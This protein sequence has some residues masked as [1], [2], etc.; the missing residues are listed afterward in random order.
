MISSVSQTYNW[1]LQPYKTWKGN[2]YNE[3]SLVNARPETNGSWILS[4]Q[5]S[6]SQDG[7]AFL[8]RPIKHWRK[9]LAANRI[10]GGT[11]NISINDI[12][13]PGLYNMSNNKECCDV[14]NNSSSIISNIQQKNNSTIYEDSE[15]TI[16]YAD[17]S[18]CWN[19]PVGKR[20]CCNPEDNLIRYKTEPIERNYISY[21]YY[22]KNRCVNYN[23]NISTTKVQGNTYFNSNGIAL[24]P[25]NS[26]NGCQVLQKTDCANNCCNCNCGTNSKSQN[27]IYKP[28]NRLFAKQGATSSKARIN[29][30]RENTIDQGG[31]L[32]NSASGL[33]KI[34]NGICGLNGDSVY[35]VKTKPVIPS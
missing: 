17:V 33:Q 8:P 2:F 32:F 10:R 30:L 28:N 34:N 5:S 21:S 6:S 4:K 23:Q 16:T 20:I 12:D 19:G 3:S 7:N 31:A 1:Q 25:T 11:Q 15:T 24:Y 26:S 14:S 13:S 35:Y 22:F 9:Q 29:A 18:N 27:T